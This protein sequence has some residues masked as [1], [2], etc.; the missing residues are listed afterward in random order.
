MNWLARIHGHRVLGTAVAIWLLVT[1]DLSAQITL[2]GTPSTPSNASTARV[3][4]TTSAAGMAV[5]GEQLVR[6]ARDAMARRDFQAAVSKYRLAAS[7]APTTPEIVPGVARLRLDLQIAG[8]DS[9]LLSTQP[10]RSAAATSTPQV[11][12]MPK[13]AGAVPIASAGTDAASRKRDALRLV[14][15]GRVAL[16]R[17]DAAAALSFARQA[18]ALKVPERDFAAGEPRVW[19]FVL[20][21]ESA[22]RRSGLTLATNGSTPVAG[23]VPASGDYNK[24]EAGMIA[25]MLFQGGD[26]PNTSA[27][28]SPNNSIADNAAQPGV[29]RQVQAESLYTGPL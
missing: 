29:I 5:S 23:V 28:N 12:A 18:Q 9:E 25:Q 21:A 6:E 11:N 2:P 7:M 13:V 20:D 27:P 4:P 24:T 15:L 1:P 8:I 14:A 22:A 3:T 19:Q 26:D 17:G 10:Q 16:D